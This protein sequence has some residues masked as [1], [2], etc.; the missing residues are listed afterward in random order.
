MFPAIVGE[1]D[2]QAAGSFRQESYANA[3]YQL[4]KVFGKQ[5]VSHH[6]SL[7]LLDVPAAGRLSERK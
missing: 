1:R 3:A 4:G 7:L 5:V 6:S 2:H